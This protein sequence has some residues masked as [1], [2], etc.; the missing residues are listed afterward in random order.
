MLV[1]SAPVH[2]ASVVSVALVIGACASGGTTGV[3]AASGGSTGVVAASSGTTTP[4]ALASPAIGLTLDGSSGT[5]PTN[6][7]YPVYIAYQRSGA[8]PVSAPEGSA[9]FNTSGNTTSLQLIIPALNINATLVSDYAKGLDQQKS[10]F[11]NGITD[12]G[13]A[14]SLGALDYVAFGGWAA[15]TI[16]EP[17]VQFLFG[18][19]T[20]VS[21][22]PSSGHATFAG[23]S[24]IGR[25]NNTALVGTATF[26]VNFGSGTLTGALSNMRTVSGPG[27]YAAWNDVSVTASIAAGS[28]RFSGNTAATSAPATPLSLSASATGRMDGAFFGP[29]A[30][31]LGAAWT[32]SDGTTSA[33]GLVIADHQ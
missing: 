23:G 26:S 33:V 28:S 31:N 10:D 30:Q 1:R 27:S 20:P 15:D 25:V 7:S 29:A 18:I 11:N 22:I 6:A 5:F 17:A 19:E 14:V 13:G 3:V 8:A 12:V 24:V 9:D 16:S 32:L 2:A 4:A 21:A